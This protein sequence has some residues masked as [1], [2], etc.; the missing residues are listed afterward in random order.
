M[1]AI[2]PVK[3]LVVEGSSIS[4]LSLHSQAIDEQVER[5]MSSCDTLNTGI[6]SDTHTEVPQHTSPLLFTAHVAKRHQ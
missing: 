2:A 6:A 5:E 3:P 4:S 1:R